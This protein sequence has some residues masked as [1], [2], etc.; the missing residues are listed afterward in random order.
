MDLFHATHRELKVGEIIEPGNWG[1]KI[2]EIGL[3]HPSWYREI[4]LEAVRLFSYPVKPSRLNCTFSCDSFDTI[5]RY[6]QHN[7][8]EGYIYKVIVLNP[9]LPTHK[10]DFN[11]VEPT[12]GSG[13]NMF[14]IANLYWQFGYKTSVDTWPGI[15]CSEILSASALQIIEIIP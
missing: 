12:P 8:P 9:S 10:G 4:I 7:C 6:K 2:L 14:Q 13:L 11:A 15:E 1:K 5:K 3:T